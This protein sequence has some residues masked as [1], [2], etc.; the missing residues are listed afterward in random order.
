MTRLVAVAALFFL[1]TR[2][3]L[4]QL[5]TPATDGVYVV[6]VVNGVPQWRPSANAA[7]STIYD[8][9]PTR[10]ANGTWLLPQTPLAGVVV[11]HVNGAY[12]RRGADYTVSGRTI[13]CGASFAA[14][15]NANAV[16]VASYTF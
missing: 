8:V 12:A 15:L 14:C 7:Q 11:L 1:Q 16:V 6:E 4:S 2:L 5:A 3:P 9:V 13:T 10:Q